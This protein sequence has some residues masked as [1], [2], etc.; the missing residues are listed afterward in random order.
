MA[1]K[2]RDSLPLCGSV[3]Y[4]VLCM[5]KKVPFP[6]Y[7]FPIAVAIGTAIWVSQGGG[8]SDAPSDSTASSSS[9]MSVAAASN[10]TGLPLQIPE[11]FS[12]EVLADDLPGARVIAQDS[13]GNYWV[14]Q[15]AQ[16]AISVIEMGDDGRPRQVYRGFNGIP[17]RGPHGLAIDPTDGLTLYVAEEHRIIRVRLYSDASI[18]EIAKLPGIGRHLEDRRSI[19]RGYDSEL[20]QW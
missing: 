11:G 18:E 4:R 17:L 19:R 1:E 16:D 3:L 20:W 5:E 13:F 15:P 8:R 9:V 7:F 12:L 10:T 2:D 14:S 6:V